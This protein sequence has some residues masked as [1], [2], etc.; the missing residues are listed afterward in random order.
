MVIIRL[1][2]H[3]AAPPERVFHLPRSI[4]LHSRWVDWTGDQAVYGCRRR[5]PAT[6]QD[7]C[8]R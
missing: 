3:I 4:E 1:S 8:R 7:F 6:G 5:V 2:T